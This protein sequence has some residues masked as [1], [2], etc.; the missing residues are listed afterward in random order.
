MLDFDRRRTF[1]AQDQGRGFRRF[2][3][4]GARPFTGQSP[5]EI[6][7]AVVQEEGPAPPE[8]LRQHR[9]LLTIAQRCMEKRP[10]ERMASAGIMADELE[11]FL[12]GEPIHARPVSAAE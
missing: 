6:L 7:Q 11:R 1:D 10:A 9:D 5:V 2:A 8:P 3:V 12:R 4:A